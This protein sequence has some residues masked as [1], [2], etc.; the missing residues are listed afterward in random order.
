M[1]RAIVI[2]GRLSDLRCADWR[3]RCQVA[4]DQSLRRSAS[5]RWL[6]EL[7]QFMRV[8]TPG[9]GTAGRLPWLQKSAATAATAAT[10]GTAGTAGTALEAGLGQRKPSQSLVAS[11]DLRRRVQPV[12]GE[13]AV[14]AVGRLEKALRCFAQIFLAS[15]RISPRTRR[16]AFRTWRQA[17]LQRHALQPIHCPNISPIDLERPVFAFCQ[18]SDRGPWFARV[19]IHSFVASAVKASGK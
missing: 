2:S 19:S 16:P 7:Q 1:H 14:A 10:A 8:M 17:R 18:M 15:C 9:I 4:E 6:I 12:I 5:P 13:P 11:D 3:G